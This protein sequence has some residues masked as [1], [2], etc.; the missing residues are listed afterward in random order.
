MRHSLWLVFSAVVWAQGVK[1]P[2][3]LH[4]WQK[5]AVTARVA[6]VVDRVLVD[7]GSVV[8]EGDV[9]VELSAPEMKAQLAE[10]EVRALAVDGGGPGSRRS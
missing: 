6:G 7:R 2:A 1:L 5:V 3:E 10:V 8:K 9:L 4:A